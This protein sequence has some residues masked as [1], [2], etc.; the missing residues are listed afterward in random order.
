MHRESYLADVTGSGKLPQW[1]LS[2]YVETEYHS[3][4]CGGRTE[5]GSGLGVGDHTHDD[6]IHLGSHLD[7]TVPHL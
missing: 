4:K 2:S 7:N 6:P 5:T 3:P 1:L